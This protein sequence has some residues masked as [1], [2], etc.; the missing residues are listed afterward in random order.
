MSESKHIKEIRPQAGFQEKFVRSNVD[1][2]F[3]G[4]VLNCGKAQPLDSKILSPNGYIRMGDVKVGDVICAS[5]GG[6]QEVTHIF[7]R[8]SLDTYRIT[9]DDG[10]QVECCPEHLWTVWD[11][12]IGESVTVEAQVIESDLN[13]YELDLHKPLHLSEAFIKS[14]DDIDKIR[15]HGVKAKIESGIIVACE[16]R[17]SFSRIES[18]GKKTM[19]CIVVSNPD[20]LYITDGFNLTHNSFGAILSLA[21]PSLDPLFRACFTR[22]TFG[23]LKSG[24]G[25]VDDLESA[26]GSYI[27]VRK[28]ENPRGTFPKGSFVELRQINDENIRKITEQWKGSQYDLIY[29]DELTSY[30]FSTFKYLLSRNRG[31]GKWTGKFRGTT[32]PEKDSWVRKFIDWYVGIDG[33]IMEERDGVVRYF[34]ITGDNVESVVWGDTKEEVYMKCKIDIDRKL[35][36][37]GKGFTYENMIKSFT[38]YLGRMSENKASIGNN[39]DYA[40]SV[41]SVGGKQA[42]QLIEGNWN[43]SSKYDDDVPIPFSAVKEV[44]VND[45]MR[46]GDK[47]ITADLAD[48]GKDNFVALVWDGFHII[49]S[50]ILGRTTPRRNAEELLKLADTYGIPNNHIIFDGVRGAYINDYIDEAIPFISYKAPFGMYGRSAYNLKD[51]CYLRL[52]KVINDNRMSFSEKVSSR[53]YVHQKLKQEITISVEFIEECSVVRFKD[54][55]IGKKRLLTKKEMNQM[56]GK[57]RSMDLLDPMAMRMLPVLEYP[58]GDELIRT[59]VVDIEDRFDDD[60]ENLH[61]SIYDDS[62]WA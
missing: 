43:V 41:A 48:T 53:K 4:G 8:G 1:V 23:E 18:I 26:F 57:G 55:G 20:H 6:V 47:W 36:A 9:F 39:M 52:A 25:L 10:T 17:K 49:D 5:D 44:L 37:L 12:N 38:F 22:R 19:R 29:M 32:N 42:Q 16:N 51:E 27:Q 3:G 61:G 62:T 11:K 15:V 14:L 2:V 13:R 56:L 46:N 58:Y 54:T 31:K 33:Q 60:E 40:G 45:E 50:V 28:S 35:K 24:G 59:A 34:Y 7:E 21:E 30:E